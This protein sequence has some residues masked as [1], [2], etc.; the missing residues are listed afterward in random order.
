MRPVARRSLGLLAVASALPAAAAA[1]EAF[2]SRPIR[3]IVPFPAG[4]I[5]DVGMRALGD[6]MAPDLGVPVVVEPRPGA[7]GAIGAAAARQARADGYTVM[8]AS[9]SHVVHPLIQ[10]RPVFDLRRDFTPVSLLFRSP[11]VLAVH[12]AL[13]ARTLEEFIAHARANPG[14]LNYGISTPGS[15]LHLATEMLRAARGLDMV[16]IPF[17]GQPPLIPNLLNGQ[18]QAAVLTLGPVLPHAREGALRM[19]AVISEERAASAPEVPTVAELGIPEMN[20]VPWWG[21]VAPAGTPEE[22]I[23]RLNGSVAAALATPEVLARLEP[24]ALS[25]AP[26]DPA[27]FARVIE[28]DAERYRR[29]FSSTRIELN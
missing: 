16:G 27:G 17:P 14:R 21:L 26:A 10:D 18:L 13:P 25:V 6:R 1:Q 29:L 20:M 3:A 28:A 12:P 19:L 23:R 4:G 7:N 8:V 24:L 15:P 22:A 5:I 2:P 11:A 9:A